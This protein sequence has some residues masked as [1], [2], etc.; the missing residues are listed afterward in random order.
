MDGTDPSELTPQRRDALKAELAQLERQLAAATRSPVD[1][2]TL[3][4]AIDQ[5]ERDR[6]ALTSPA[7]ESLR[8]TVEDLC[9]DLEHTWSGCTQAIINAEQVAQKEPTVRQPP[10]LLPAIEAVIHAHDHTTAR[11]AAAHIDYLNLSQIPAHPHLEP[12]EHR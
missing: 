5:A 1:P 6:D 7:V 10:S 2:A 9:A 12:G 4:A 11:L 8:E 3:I